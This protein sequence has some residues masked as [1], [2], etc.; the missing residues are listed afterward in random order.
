MK[1]RDCGA[2]YDAGAPH[3]AFCPAKTCTECGASF[4][5]VLPVYDSRP[6]AKDEEG[7]PPRLCDECLNPDDAD[8]EEDDEDL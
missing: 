2:E 8:D 1:C 3:N 5:Y 4:G 6:E 7:N